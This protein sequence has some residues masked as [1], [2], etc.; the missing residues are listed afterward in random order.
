MPSETGAC[1]T[2]KYGL[3]VVKDRLFEL[4]DGD[5]MLVLILREGK[6]IE[7]VGAAPLVVV[8]KQE[9]NARAKIS[10]VKQMYK[11]LFKMLL[12]RSFLKNRM[13]AFPLDSLSQKMQKMFQVGESFFSEELLKCYK[14]GLAIKASKR[15][16]KRKELPLESG[17]NCQI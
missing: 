2:A 8:P 13:T 11:S 5:S 14:I 4:V 6:G 10:N 1:V 17:K 15:A 16:R 3:P 9:F 7:A 12:L